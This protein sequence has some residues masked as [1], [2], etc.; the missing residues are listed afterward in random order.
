MKLSIILYISTLSFSSG[1][2]YQVLPQQTYYVNPSHASHYNP[3]RAGYNPYQAAYFNPSQNGYLNPLTTGSLYNGYAA[4]GIPYS[5]AYLY[6][7]GINSQLLNPTSNSKTVD[8][9]TLTKSHVQFRPQNVVSNS[10]NS[11]GIRNIFNPYPSN[12]LQPQAVTRS[13][14]SSCSCEVDF[15]CSYNC[16]KCSALCHSCSC[17]ESQ[18]CRYNCDK[19]QNSDS[20]TSEDGQTTEMS[21]QDST[22]SSIDTLDTSEDTTDN[23]AVDTTESVDADTTEGVDV[24]TTEVVDVDTTEGVDANAT[25]ESQSDGEATEASVTETSDVDSTT[26]QPDGESTDEVEE[27]E[28]DDEEVQGGLINPTFPLGSVGDTDIAENG[29]GSGSSYST[30]DNSETSVIGS[31]DA[32][33][34]N[35]TDCTPLESLEVNLCSW[36]PSCQT[37]VNAVYPSC[38]YNCTSCS[39]NQVGGCVASSGSA[40]GQPCIFPFIYNGVA[41]NGCAPLH[42]EERVLDFWCSTKTDINGIHITGPFEDPGKYVGFCDDSCPRDVPGFRIQP[43]FKLQ[44]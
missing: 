19:C 27:S 33:E 1:R 35:G 42:S 21:A 17:E 25:T 40:V 31:G 23:S 8:S 7:P 28:E 29:L 24:D 41:Y 16:E 20:R 22:D 36:G 5:P 44:G 38:N 4:A 32:A 39:I 10:Q 14:C 30:D 12:Y 18:G 9:S 11:L 15:G 13:L 43:G 26:Q 2:R 3:L 34:N 37:V 6:S